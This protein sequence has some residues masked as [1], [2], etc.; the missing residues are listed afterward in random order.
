VSIDKPPAGLRA[1]DGARAQLGPQIK[2]IAEPL[3]F[4]RFEVRCDV[5]EEQA[6]RA[7]SVSGV[8]GYT[9][10]AEVVVPPATLNQYVR[11]NWRPLPDNE[12]IAACDYDIDAAQ[13]VEDWIAAGAPLKW[14]PSGTTGTE[15]DNQ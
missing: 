13:L 1:L 11:V 4:Y 6:R 5:S 3:G 8:F 10:K 9:F 15:E 12:T 14:E 2:Y 7:C